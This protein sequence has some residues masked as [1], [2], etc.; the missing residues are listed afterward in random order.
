VS[1]LRRLLAFLGLGR[2]EAP[3][4]PA[5]SSPGA[6]PVLTVGEATGVPLS[7]LMQAA[8]FAEPARWAALLAGPML[9]HGISGRARI[10]AFLATLAHESDGGRRLEEDL[11]YTAARAAAVW[12]S[13]FPTPAA[14]AHVALNPPALAEAVYGGRLGNTEPGAAW[15]YRGRGLIQITG[16]VNYGRAAD[17]LS[18]PLM[19]DPDMAAQP[20]TAAQ[21]AAW[22]WSE[23]GCNA[24]A[25]AGDVAAWRRRVNGGLHGLDD[26]TRRYAAVL[27]AM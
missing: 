19:G 15:R 1:L 14:A 23:N 9:C 24:L 5:E 17:A 6:I 25:D 3:A 21:I 18:L 10:A 12:P 2:S 22:W 27:R 7:R 8:G 4:A 16:A 20:E 26:V 11:S 13:R